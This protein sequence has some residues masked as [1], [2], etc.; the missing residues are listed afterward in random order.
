MTVSRF[1]R[2]W[3]LQPILSAILA[4]KLRTGKACRGRTQ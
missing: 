3:V 1:Y 2:R 4:Y